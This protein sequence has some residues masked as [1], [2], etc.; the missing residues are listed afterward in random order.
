VFTA[1]FDFIIDEFSGSTN[2]DTQISQLSVA[3]AG[4]GAHELG[5]T[6]GLQHH[7][8]YGD[9]A[10]TTT[11]GTTPITTGGQQNTHIIATGSTGIDE[12]GRETSRTF[13]E[14]E[15]AKLEFTGGAD[16]IFF[17]SNVTNNELV[18][19]P[20]TT[21]LETGATQTGGQALTFN[22]LTVS[23]LVA[24]SVIGQLSSAGEVD[25]YTFTGGLGRLLTVEVLSEIRFE[26]PIDSLITL[27]DPDGLTV[28]T[29]DDL[30]YS[31]NTFQGGTLRS[32]DSL[33]L[34]LQLTKTGTYTLEV[35]DL[36]TDTGLY[37][38][39]VASDVPEPSTILGTLAAVGLGAALM[40]K[41][42]QRQIQG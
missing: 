33:L 13:S 17:G 1:N 10:I 9:P 7:D 14:Y 18:A 35:E 26:N 5:H 42:R 31:G 41:S 27:I 16:T 19:T 12:V 11:D 8:A 23:D 4:T 40:W 25:T 22:T 3:L 15:N 34:N 24:T 2:R 20:I 6:F 37:S 38:L 32:T 39:F 21:L 36:A 30:F 28:A 29:N